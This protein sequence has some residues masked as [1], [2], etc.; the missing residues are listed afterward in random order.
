MTSKTLA[1]I[2]ITT[3]ILLG[4]ILVAILVTLQSNAP[5]KPDYNGCYTDDGHGGWEWVVPCPA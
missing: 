5:A 2:A 1:L 3:Q 4:L